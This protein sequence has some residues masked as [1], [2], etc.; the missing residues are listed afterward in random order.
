MARRFDSALLHLAGVLRRFWRALDIGLREFAFLLGLAAL[1][2]GL[3][4]VDPRVAAVVVGGLLI[5]LGL[6]FGRSD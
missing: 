4:G 3:Y 1:G 2:S 5:Y 6:F